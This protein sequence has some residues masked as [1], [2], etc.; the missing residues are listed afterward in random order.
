MT[1][2]EYCWIKKTQEQRFLLVKYPWPWVKA[3]VN[4]LPAL[5]NSAISR[6]YTKIFFFFFLFAKIV[7]EKREKNKFFKFTKAAVEPFPKGQVS[8]MTRKELN[9]GCFFSCGEERRGIVSELS[10]S[11]HDEVWASFLGQHALY[12]FSVSFLFCLFVCLFLATWTYYT[13]STK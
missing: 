11:V 13:R 7:S 12:F 10:E 8:T 2:H 5:K 1:C 4:F 3:K 6:V 9:G